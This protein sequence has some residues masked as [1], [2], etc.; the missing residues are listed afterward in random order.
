M[1]FLLLKSYLD[2]Q[3]FYNLKNGMESFAT[4][5]RIYFDCRKKGKTIR[6]SIDVLIALTA[7]ENSLYLLHND[8]DF[9]NIQSVIPDLIFY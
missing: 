8:K 3:G 4:A 9:V 1:D 7:I 2:S 5:A 6:S